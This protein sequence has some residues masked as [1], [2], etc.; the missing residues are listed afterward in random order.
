MIL[1]KEVVVA[2][3]DDVLGAPKAVP[4]RHRLVDQGELRV[5]IL[6]ID[7]E[8]NVFNE[9]PHEVA[10]FQEL[11]LHQLPRRNIDH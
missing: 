1:P 11:L 7:V 6:E 3:A 5:A 10:L 2:L 4:L 9:Q 8:R